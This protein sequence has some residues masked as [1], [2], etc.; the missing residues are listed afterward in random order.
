MICVNYIWRP[1]D[2]ILNTKFIILVYNINCKGKNT[3][4]NIF[5]FS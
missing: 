3:F 5:L 4:A 1:L 2:L